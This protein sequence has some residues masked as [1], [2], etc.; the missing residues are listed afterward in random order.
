VTCEGCGLY[1]ATVKVNG[2]NVCPA[3]V[4]LPSE[5]GEAPTVEPID[6]E[7]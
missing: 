4:D 2:F 6:E 1:P 5:S 7:S 3:C